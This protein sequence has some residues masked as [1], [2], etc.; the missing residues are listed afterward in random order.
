VTEPRDHLQILRSAGISVTEADEQ[1]VSQSV[2]VSLAALD[3]AVKSSLF[4][5]EPQT[6]DVV[7]RKLARRKSHG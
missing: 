3:A 7:L 2:Q 4:D 6:F 5:T 1:R